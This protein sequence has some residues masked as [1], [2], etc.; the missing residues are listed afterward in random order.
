LFYNPNE[1]LTLNGLSANAPVNTIGSVILKRQLNNHH[2]D[3]K[4]HVRLAKENA[5]IP[6]DGLLGNNFLKEQETQIDYNK[7]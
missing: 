6:F 4:F 3:M 7:L 1:T 2:L 5:N